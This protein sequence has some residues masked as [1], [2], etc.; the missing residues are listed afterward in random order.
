MEK[1][2]I[3][4]MGMRYDDFK[5]VEQFDARLATMALA[6]KLN[7]VIDHLNAQ[8][9]DTEEWPQWNHE[10]WS[11]NSFGELYSFTWR[12]TSLDKEVQDFIGI[13][14]TKKEAEAH[15]EAIKSLNKI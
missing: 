5:S 13:F 10:V 4:K 12:G 3:L 2:D 14:K 8:P 9:K 11:L 7:E 1:I 15:K 6:E